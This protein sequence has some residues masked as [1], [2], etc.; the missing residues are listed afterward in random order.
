[1]DTGVRSIRATSRATFPF[2]MIETWVYL[3]NAGGGGLLGCWVY[4]CT[5]DSAGIQN[6]EGG[7]AEWSVG[8]VQP[9]ANR[10]CE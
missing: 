1:M 6:F 9:V 10:I 3:S 2:P 4:Q 8:M 7:R 5:M